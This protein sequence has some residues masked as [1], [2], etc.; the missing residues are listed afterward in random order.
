ME[1]SLSN[2]LII[3]GTGSS[4]NC[5][6][7]NY[8][9]KTIIFDAGVKPKEALQYCEN[10]PE[11]LILS[12]FHNDHSKYL[13]DFESR[14]I[15]VIY[16][17]NYSNDR[18]KVAYFE[19]EHDL[20]NFGYYVAIDGYYVVYITDTASINKF[21]KKVDLLLIEVNFDDEII[22]EHF[23][24]DKIEPF[25]YQR[26]KNNHLSFV[27]SLDFIKKQERVSPIDLIVFIH[28]SDSRASEI[29]LLEMAGKITGTR[30][31]IAQNK[32]VIDLKLF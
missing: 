24:N 30:I 5:Y 14:G 32:K 21:F 10:F 3:A 2:K 12:H 31:K 13:S 1:K 11:L 28:L 8:N 27:K 7:I 20:T 22:D 26:I 18:I 17:Q 25:L 29:K 4:G 9:D 15:K 19:L 23:L 16:G 6:I